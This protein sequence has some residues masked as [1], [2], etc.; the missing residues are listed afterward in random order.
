M[1]ETALKKAGL[2]GVKPTRARRY[3]TP[4]EVGQ[5]V[6]A[7]FWVLSNAQ[8]S[9]PFVGLV[10]L[11]S[12]ASDRMSLPYEYA[13]NTPVKVMVDY[14]APVLV[15]YVLLF[16]LGGKTPVQAAVVVPAVVMFC[17]PE[18]T[19]NMRLWCFWCCC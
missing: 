15:A 13:M 10:G 19:S 6:A 2:S 17:S 3:L 14:G 8:K 12:G 18:A 5:L 16:V 11:G 9:N 4:D 7:T 1:T